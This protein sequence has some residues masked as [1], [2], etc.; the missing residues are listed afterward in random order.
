MTPFYLFIGVFLIY[1]FKNNITF[2]R[3]KYFLSLFLIIFIFSPMAYYFA[4]IT[5]KNKKT[6]STLSNLRKSVYF[7][8]S[9]GLEVHAG[10]GLTYK[11]VYQ[12]NKIKNISEFNIGHFI[13]SESLFVGIK[14]SIKKFKKI[15][16][17]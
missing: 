14:N 11:S 10:H 2:N 8:E 5:N 15:I 4:S 12:I 3:I 1:I 17:K 7:A 6:K 16:N 9:L 13:I